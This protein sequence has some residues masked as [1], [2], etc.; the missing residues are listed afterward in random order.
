MFFDFKRKLKDIIEDNIGDVNEV[1]EYGN[2][3]LH[4]AAKQSNPKLVWL[5][6]RK[7]INFSIKNNIGDTALHVAC[8]HHNLY[9]AE[10]LFRKMNTRNI[11]NSEGKRPDE[12]LTKLEKQAFEHFEDRLLG[13]GKYQYKPKK[14]VP[15][16]FGH[17]DYR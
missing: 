4:Y 14:E 2:T 3:L 10:E 1:D 15:H 11:K 5:L 16:Y 12:Y 9:T 7:N 6:N 13:F 8:K 17:D